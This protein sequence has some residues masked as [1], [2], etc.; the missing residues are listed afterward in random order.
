MSRGWPE[1]SSDIFT[2]RGLRPVFPTKRRPPALILFKPTTRLERKSGEKLFRRQAPAAFA[3]Q[4]PDPE[5]V[6]SAANDDAGFVGG[7]DQTGL[8]GRFDDLGAPDFQ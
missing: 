3:L 4:F 5:R 6:L 2:Q 8:A 7:Q 1:I